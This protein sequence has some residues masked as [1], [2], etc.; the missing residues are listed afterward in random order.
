MDFLVALPRTQRGRDSFIVV[1]D[2]FTKMAHFM[3]YHKTDDASHF[4][5]LYFKEIIRLHGVSRTIVSDRDTKFLSHLWRR[6][7][8]LLETK[9]LYSNTC[10]PQ[11]DGQIEITNRILST[12]LRTLV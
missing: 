10:H 3:A 12:L 11:S 6:L 8:H 1:V 4:G 9:L 2:R 7:W 5:D